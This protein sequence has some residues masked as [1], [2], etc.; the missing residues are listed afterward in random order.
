MRRW[1]GVSGGSWCDWHATCSSDGLP[2]NI[3]PVIVTGDDS[4][5]E[6]FLSLGEDA[7]TWALPTNFPERHTSTVHAKDPEGEPPTVKSTCSAG[8]PACVS[9]GLQGV[10]VADRTVTVT[11]RAPSG[12]DVE[13]VVGLQPRPIAPA[14]RATVSPSQL[15]V[16]SPRYRT[17]S[18]R[19]CASVDRLVTEL[20]LSAHHCVA[21]SPLRQ[22]GNE[23][24]ADIPLG[25]ERSRE[26]GMG[27]PAE[28][29]ACWPTSGEGQ[30]GTHEHDNRWERPVT[31]SSRTT[32]S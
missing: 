15:R 25:A 4:R 9:C 24:R 29:H 18:P 8:M 19:R 11:E 27:V 10:R 26:P 23:G 21:R 32:L 13:L 3:S 22:W 20:I 5:I 12:T 2:A 14:Q 17:L 31:S 30:C 6:A 1:S 28:P 7:V 16:T